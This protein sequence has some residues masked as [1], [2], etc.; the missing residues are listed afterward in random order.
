MEFSEIGKMA[1]KFWLETPHYFP[2]VELD[3]F[4]IMPNHVHGIII[5]D[6]PDGGS[7]VLKYQFSLQSK[8]LASIIR[9]FKI[10]VT[11]HTHT[12]QLNFA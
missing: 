1:E 7:N 12:I 5:I 8:I 11:K 10:G 9:G 6:K 2:F 4:V 3:A